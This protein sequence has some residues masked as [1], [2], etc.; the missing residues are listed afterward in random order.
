MQPLFFQRVPERADDVVLANQAAEVPRPP[1]PR[2]YLIAHV[3]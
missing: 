2:K 1:L 3:Y